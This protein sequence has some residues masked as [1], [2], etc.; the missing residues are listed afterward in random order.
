MGDASLF[1]MIPAD[2]VRIDNLS[3]EA[4]K[5]MQ[6]KA[7]QGIWPTVAQLGYRNVAGS[8]RQEIIEPDPNSAP[9]ITPF[10]RRVC[11]RHVVIERGCGEGQ[12]RV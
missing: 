6:E 9:L 10:V 5:G 11:N 1:N 4:R 8:D 2:L 3:E 7:E 12:Q